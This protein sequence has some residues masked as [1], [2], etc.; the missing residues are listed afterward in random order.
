M[1]ELEVKGKKLRLDEDGF[2]QDWEEWDEEVAEALAKDTRFSPQPIELTEEHWKIIKYLRDYFIK[3][4][5]APPVRML[6]K[7]CKKEV[8]PDCNLQYIYKLFPQGPAKDA[9][10]IAGLPKPTGCV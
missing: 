9:C 1:P 7:H 6:V 3:Y 2:L 4:G 8:K 10:R 5:V